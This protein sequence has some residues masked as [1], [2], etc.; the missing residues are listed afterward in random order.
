MINGLVGTLLVRV[1]ARRVAARMTTKQPQKH[2]WLVV[3]FCGFSSVDVTCCSLGT[4]ACWP[5]SQHHKFL[6]VL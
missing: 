5:E 4:A 3:L 2:A 6:W 1:G